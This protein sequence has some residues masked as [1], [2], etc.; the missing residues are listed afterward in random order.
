MHCKCYKIVTPS[1]LMVWRVHDHLRVEHMYQFECSWLQVSHGCIEDDSWIWLSG[2]K[3]KAIKSYRNDFLEIAHK[4][5]F[6]FHDFHHHSIHVAQVGV[7]KL[8]VGLRLDGKWNS[9]STVQ[10]IGRILSAIWKQSKNT[11][12]A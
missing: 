9:S 2:E 8:E 5:P 3:E 4:S 1:W 12:K 11:F 7:T 6:R 10:I